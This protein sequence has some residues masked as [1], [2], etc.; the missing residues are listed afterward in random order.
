MV[1]RTVRRVVPRG[2]RRDVTHRVSGQPKDVAG[3]IVAGQ[4]FGTVQILQRGEVVARVPLVAAASVPVADLEQKAKA[5]FT[6]PVAILLAF[7]VLAGTVLIAR[8]LRRSLR[9]G[10][11][12]GDEARAA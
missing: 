7:A 6:G 10:R 1:D 3:P 5:W 11:R 8:Q 2:R 4:R 9:D 12:A